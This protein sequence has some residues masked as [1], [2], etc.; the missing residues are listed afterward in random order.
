M[1]QKT[2]LLVF[3]CVCLIINLSCAAR[4]SVTADIK[5]K[6][7]YSGAQYLRGTGESFDSAVV[8]SGGKSYSDALLCEDKFISNMWGVK[9]KDW[10][11]IEKTTVTE[12]NKTYDMIQVEIPKVG[13]KH[14]YYFDVSRYFKKKKT[15][16]QEEE[17]K[18]EEEKINSE[19]SQEKT[20]SNEE[21]KQQIEQSPQDTSKP[22]TESKE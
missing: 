14:F 8:I 2:Y 12:N 11:L 1:R 18:P 13:E 3:L 21:L 5:A 22:Q 19:T 16:A 4:Q 20:K 17:Q 10:R 9:D 7:K 6:K 15:Q